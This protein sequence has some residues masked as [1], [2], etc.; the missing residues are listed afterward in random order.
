MAITLYGFGPAFGLPDPSP[1]VT[2]AIIL[3]AM[4]ERPFERRPANLRRAPKGKIPY[5][6][7]DGVTVSDSTFI[8][9]HIEAKYGVDFDR[10]LSP[11][12]RGVAWAFER[13]MEEQFYFSLLYWR[14][15]D[16]DS[17][18]RGPRHFFQAVP[19]PIRPL[20]MAY[21]RRQVRKQL[22]AQGMGR[23]SEPEIIGLS[24]RALD[25]LAAHLGDKPFLM[26]DLPCGADAGV[27]GQISNA[28]SPH[29]E[30]ELTALM[31]SYPSLL[32]YSE[33]VI[34]RWAPSGPA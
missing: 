8:R 10:G 31:R 4:A 18:D 15:L 34:A 19:A 14:W 32:A 27:V 20:L 1:F 11:A 3:L 13:M 12:E 9:A 26:G 24:R 21:V 16:D 2:K 22:V 6:V 25:A 17:F 33:R 29:F 30:N 7:D 28:A 5:I 23:H